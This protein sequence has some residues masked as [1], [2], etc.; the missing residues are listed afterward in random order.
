VSGERNDVTIH[1][2]AQDDNTGK[3]FKKVKEDAKRGGAAA[4][5]EF[6]GSFSGQLMANKA[7]MGKAGDTLG[8]ETAK[9][10]EKAV[11]AA[12]PIVVPV[13]ADNPVDAAWRAK[14]QASIKSVAGSALDVPVTPETS[15]FRR[16][17]EVALKKASGLAAAKI[18]V[19]PEDATKFR[20]QLE[21]M[22]A[23]AA[24]GVKANIPV[25]VDEDEID[26][27]VNR[28]N[29]KFGLISFA[30]LSAGLPAAALAG[31]VATGAILAAVPLMFG[32][33]AA[34][35]LTNNAKVTSS[36]HGTA[37]KVKA[38][39][40][41]MALPLEGTMVKA[42]EKV[43]AS[44]TR[45]Q[46]AI[47]TAMLAS[48]SGVLDLTDSVLGLAE[49]AL[50]GMVDAAEN[51]TAALGG[52]E[53]MM[54][55]VGTGAGDMF[56]AM[57]EGSAG[58]G[59]GMKVTGGILH[60]LLGFTG[61][62]FANLANG[63]AGPLRDFQ[64][65]LG[66][67][68]DTA[69]SLTSNGMPALQ[70]VT[71]GFLN[72]VSGG[73]GI[74]KMGADALGSWAGPLGSAT[75]TLLGI[76]S[77]AKLFGTS[78]G[79]TGFGVRA[80]SQTLDASGKATTPFRQAL[81]DTDAGGGKF[82]RGLGS[83]LSQGVNPLGI[84]LV[85]GGLLLDAYGRKQQEAAKMAA[86]HR[87]NV[88]N[89]T[90]AIRQDNGVL[91]ENSAKVNVAALTSKNAESN[92]RVFGATMGTA[93]LAIEGNSQAYDKLKFSSGA[94]IADIAKQSG[95]NETQT[96]N[97]IG[98]GRAAL[99]TGQNWD[100]M[101]TAAMKAEPTLNSTG[102]AIFGVNGKLRDQLSAIINGNGAVGEQIRAQQEAQRVYVA[103]QA[104][105]T[106]MS[107][108]QV[109]AAMSTNE[110]TAALY[111]QQNASLGLRGAELNT[112]AA[113]EEY[114]KVKDD[115]KKTDAEKAASLLKVE[116][117]FATQEQAAYQNAFALNANKGEVMQATLAN[118]AANAMA[119]QL[120]N[121]FQ[122]AL[123]ASVSTMIS[124]FTAAQATAAG[125]TL[126]IDN[127]GAAVY[128][129]P[130]GKTIRIDAETNPADAALA[131][132]RGRLNAIDGKIIT[133]YVDVVTRYRSVGTAGVRSGINAP[134]FYVNGPHAAVGGFLGDAPIRRFA[135]GGS[136]GA[137]D[138]TQG[139]KL[140]G[141]GTGTSDDILMMTSHG[142]AAGSDDEF[143]VKA[144][145]ADKYEKLL[146]AINN[147]TLASY[148][149]GGM[150]QA[151]DGTWVPPSFY[152]KP[153]PGPHAIYTESG[154]AKL[155]SHATSF[156]IGALSAKDQDQLRTYGGW[157]EPPKQ[158]GSTSTTFRGRQSSGGSGAPV[159]IE[160][161]SS[162]TAVDNF[163]LELLRNAI[164]VQGG[165]VQTVIGS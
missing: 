63:S 125:L 117:A 162:G 143:V 69:L 45:M 9:G 111:A 153:P 86:E 132:L 114:D 141:P 76:N 37:E 1:V 23:A 123:P 32:G 28:T 29:K 159:V 99:E 38:D 58:A 154:F 24:T 52:F 74:L 59:E 105:L 142:V 54:S 80:F 134:D 97:L 91:G 49:N 160:L 106:G 7:E 82:S 78:I 34:A 12:R 40:Y 68:E 5:E 4:G 33:V 22:V 110:H 47:Q 25:E 164:R 119:V 64:G 149:G 10:A 126:G 128:R 145:Q 118:N 36:W 50:P 121:T 152:D 16:D 109:R 75:G 93:K 3:V 136:T 92:L 15:Q 66:A 101:S 19:Q 6:A 155:R 122:G 133:S 150:I 11:K 27:L 140:F 31:A 53:S 17:L 139:G 102:T 90:D 20:A 70:G 115:G 108:A 151:E 107:D 13:V 57:S 148:A 56:S 94:A 161:R 137:V 73:V 41:A 43:S 46:P 100:Q 156:G 30:A 131:N 120:A 14:V 71:S 77:A 98:M 144:R 103:S 39:T 135:G 51:S 138:V 8:K 130:N 146:Y 147:D 72:V 124:K 81:A 2:K 60:D 61:E 65:T 96:K 35:A 88:R 18:P 67:V 95:L 112:K 157:V 129:L 127:T 26:K 83:I 113:L 21:A 84:A 55:D 104:A 79:D 48:E 87:E 158:N 89:L 44:F 163:L 165:N 42:S 116:Q 62:L 85:G